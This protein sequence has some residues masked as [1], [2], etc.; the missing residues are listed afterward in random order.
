M[1]YTVTENIK[2]SE[3]EIKV[4]EVLKK[5]GFFFEREVSFNSCRNKVTK[6]LL[7]FDF[8]IPHANL[9]IEYDGVDF[10]LEADVK[11]RDKQ[12]NDW[13]KDNGITLLRLQGLK[14]IEEKIKNA[15]GISLV[16][17]ADYSRDIDTQEF[18]NS[19]LQAR[20]IKADKLLAKKIKNMAKRAAFK[21]R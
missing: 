14:F 3:A 13:A 9:L 6:Q 15:I 1:K 18:T 4:I 2:P 11:G 12:K 7:R 19:T 10:H 21:R 8:Y 20:K 16:W 17:V 5:L